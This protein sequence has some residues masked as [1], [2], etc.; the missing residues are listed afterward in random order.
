MHEWFIDCGAHNAGMCSG[1]C[2]P[3]LIEHVNASKVIVRKRMECISCTNFSFLVTP[4]FFCLMLFEELLRDQSIVF[5]EFKKKSARKTSRSMR[6]ARYGR[7]WK[8][9]TDKIAIQSFTFPQASERANEWALLRARANRA[10]WSKRTSERCERTSE[11]I[12]E[13]PSTYVSI[14]VCSR[15]QCITFALGI[16]LTSFITAL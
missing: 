11:R 12:S 7:K 5:R 14:L 8:K 6:P 4:R 13:W 9:K 15:P 3:S 10:V 1:V 16:N 2:G